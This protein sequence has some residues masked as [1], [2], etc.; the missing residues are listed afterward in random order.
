MKSRHKI[1]LLF[2]LLVTAILLGVS[3]SVYYFSALERQQ[4]YKKRLTSRALNYAQIF[5]YFSDSSNS[6]LNRINTSSMDLIARK[7]VEIYDLAGN[8]KYS[9]A[10]QSGDTIGIE[11]K[12]IEECVTNQHYYYKVRGREALAIQ[13][14]EEGLGGAV[15]IVAGYDIDGWTQLKQLRQIFMFA[16]LLGIVV[17][18]IAG[19]VFSEQLLKPV[20]QIIKEVN[21]ISS[22]NLSHRIQAGET[23]DEL[24]QLANTFNELLD[25]LQ[26][27]FTSQRRFISNASHELSTPLTSISSQLQV[28]LQ[29][30]R[31]TDE[32]RQV[33][34]SV[35]EDVM[36][37]RELTKSLLEI[38]KT[39]SQGSIELNEIRIDEILFKVMADMKK[40][41]PEYEVELDF[42]DSEDSSD[43]GFLVF[44]NGD[45]LYI[46]A[47]N[48]VEN[49]CKYS[50][51]HVARVDLSFQNGSII[52]QVKSGGEPIAKEEM[53]KIFLPFYRSSNSAGKSGFGLGLALAKRITGLHK[54]T[55]EV[56]SDL[57]SGTSFTIT[58]PALRKETIKKSP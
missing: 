6:V 34:Q 44:G 10:M 16:L 22:H 12:V 8:K 52:I 40:A 26:E 21:D 31:T 30:N 57:K 14:A 37:M 42:I 3:L 49:G 54:G 20:A 45:L 43:Y 25:R 46:A 56:I 53:E 24:N 19:H 28:A 58:L 17:T 9:Y 13:Y 39:G 35:Q 38:A 23:Q 55:L 2:T 11:Q 50:N 48:L 33:M 41:N 36:Q 5:S 47:K 32:Y 18:L 15:V 29:R 27:S 7:S 51:D 1:T 4:I